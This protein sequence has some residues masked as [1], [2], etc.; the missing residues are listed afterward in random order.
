MPWSIPALVMAA[1]AGSSKVGGKPGGEL[2]RDERVEAQRNQAE[3]RCDAPQ[4]QASWPHRPTPASAPRFMGRSGREP[5]N[6]GGSCPLPESTEIARVRS[7]LRRRCTTLYF[8]ERAI[9]SPRER[10]QS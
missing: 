5:M 1:F 2:N 7:F 6:N 10:R 9:A 4:P 3:P 8:Y